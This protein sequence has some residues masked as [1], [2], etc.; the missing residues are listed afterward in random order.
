M[1]C[2][3]ASG[4]LIQK[5]MSMQ[6]ELSPHVWKAIEASCRVQVTYDAQCVPPIKLEK[7]PPNDMLRCQVQGQFTTS[8]KVHDMCKC[9]DGNVNSRTTQP[10]SKTSLTW[11]TVEIVMSGNWQNVHDMC[12]CCWHN[13]WI[14]WYPLQ[15]PDTSFGHAESCMWKKPCGNWWNRGENLST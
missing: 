7:Q 4:D 12:N 8:G 10:H 15:H 2:T 11:A 14:R 3:N 6:C 5:I 9:W 13:W 1:A